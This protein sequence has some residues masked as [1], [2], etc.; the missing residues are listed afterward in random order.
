M[1][2]FADLG[3]RSVDNPVVL[4]LWPGAR[5]LAIGDFD[6]DGDLDL[7]V[8]GTTVGLRQLKGTGTGHFITVTNLID[9][10]ATNP[11]FPKPVYSLSAFRP[12]GQGRDELAVTHAD[13]DLIW[14]LGAGADGAL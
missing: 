7:A 10:S 6:G 13:S 11:D 5:N 14:I 4:D 2:V 1:R 8:A 12:P 9:L 3:G